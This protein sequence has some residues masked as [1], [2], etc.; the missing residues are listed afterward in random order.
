MTIA[1]MGTFESAGGVRLRFRCREAESPRGRLLIVHG[2]GDHSGRYDRMASRAAAAGIDC[3][4]LDLRGHGESEG[5][6]GHTRSF[7]RL[8]EDIDHFRRL[9]GQ[10]DSGL[11]TVLFGHSLGGLIVGRFVQEYGFP[12][13][14]GAVLSAPF[15]GLALSP[16]PWKLRLASVADWMLPWL[17]MYDEIRA[18]MLFRTPEEQR[19]REEDPLVHH[20]ITARLFGEMRRQAAIMVRRAGQCRTAFLIQLPGD[21]RVVDTAAGRDFS[22]RLAGEVRV[23]EYEEA[24]HDLYRDPVAERAYADLATWLDERFGD[25]GSAR[26]AVTL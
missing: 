11:P 12:S 20:R 21:D 16:S 1:R 14:A 25:R 24:F 18:D 4:G 26:A 5:R 7:D 10:R 2:L 9:A 3:F 17:G 22:T 6:R 13:L 23:I 19:A 15:V 8:L